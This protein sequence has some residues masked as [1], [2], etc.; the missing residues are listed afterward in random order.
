[1]ARSRRAH[2]QGLVARVRTPTGS[3]KEE[4]RMIAAIDELN[5]FEAFKKDVLPKLRTLISDNAPT[6]D[7]LEAARAIAVARL[8]TLAVTEPDAKTA[9]ASIKELLERTDGKVTDKKEVT[10]A[11]S[12]LKDEELDALVLST[13]NEDLLDEE[14]AD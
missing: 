14:A 13:V 4:D 5:E 7:L 10:H 6:K 12:K 8:A 9:L 2:Y 1:M 11:M 3:N